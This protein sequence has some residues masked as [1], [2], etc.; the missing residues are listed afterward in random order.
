MPDA[1]DAFTQAVMLMALTGA[2]FGVGAAC[3]VALVVDRIRRAV[4]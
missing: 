3:L 2:A 1:D 4:G